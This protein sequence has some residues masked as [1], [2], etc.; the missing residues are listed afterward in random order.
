MNLKTYAFIALAYGNVQIIGECMGHTPEHAREHAY[1]QL[2]DTHP[3][4]W[5]VYSV[6]LR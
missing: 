2:L 1:T 6:L 3:R 4:M 5:P